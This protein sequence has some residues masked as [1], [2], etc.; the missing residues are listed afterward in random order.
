V[1]A[2]KRQRQVGKLAFMEEKMAR[3]IEI[4]NKRPIENIAGPSKICPAS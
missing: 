2:K 3:Q 4:Y 1:L